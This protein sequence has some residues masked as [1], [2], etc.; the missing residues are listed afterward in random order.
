[1]A[2][3]HFGGLMK[4][5]FVFAAAGLVIV[6]LS[7]SCDRKGASNAGQETRTASSFT[8]LVFDNYG[9]TVTVTGPPENVLVYDRRNSRRDCIRRLVSER[10][11]PRATGYYREKGLW[12]RPMTP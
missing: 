9:R 2:I 5:Y 1:M 11:L 7:L 3:Y 6:L 4:K 10:K 8:P 12:K